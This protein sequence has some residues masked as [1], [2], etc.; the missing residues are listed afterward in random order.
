MT[1]LPDALLLRGAEDLLAA[2]V[3][4]IA[5]QLDAVRKPHVLGMLQVPAVHPGLGKL[6]RRIGR[7]D[8]ARAELTTAVT[9]LREM[10]MLHWLPEATREL[11]QTVAR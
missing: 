5:V 10:G 4:A 2:I 7:Q 8:E 9:M 11:E 1:A 3:D 6:Y